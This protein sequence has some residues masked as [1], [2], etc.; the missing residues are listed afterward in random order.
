MK[1]MLLLDV[2]QVCTQ[3]LKNNFGIAPEQKR[4]FGDEKVSALIAKTG[5][6]DAAAAGR[7]LSVF[8]HHTLMAGCG[9]TV[10]DE[11]WK[12]A[13]QIEYGGA[14]F[15]HSRYRITAPGFFLFA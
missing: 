3:H 7:Q 10:F 15:H 8:Y 12:R 9:E 4:V 13:F 1:L 6:I 5:N 14:F 11:V 2:L